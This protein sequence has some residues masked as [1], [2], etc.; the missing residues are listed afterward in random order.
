MEHAETKQTAATM[1]YAKTIYVNVIQDMT[2]KITQIVQ[3]S[4]NKSSNPKSFIHILILLTLNDFPM[5]GR[6]HQ[7]K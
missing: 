5:A 6:S 1:V 3:V 7:L 4:C 2:I